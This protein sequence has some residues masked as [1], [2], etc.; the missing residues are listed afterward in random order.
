MIL[1]AGGLFSCRPSRHVPEY[2]HLLDRYRIE[3]TAKDVN[4]NELKEYIRQ[5]PN[6]RILG[7]RFHL[8]V[9]NMANPAKEGWPHNWLRRIGEEPVIYDPF[10]TQRSVMLVEQ[11]LRNKGYYNAAVNDTVSIR[12][13]R[14][15]VTYMSIRAWLIILHL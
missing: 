11:Y 14:A 13:S 15:K 8:W 4:R 7:L 5:K 1:A 12:K 9:Y 10:V 3:S 6:K 2:D